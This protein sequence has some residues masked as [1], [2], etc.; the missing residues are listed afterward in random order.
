MQLT[1]SAGCRAP[2]LSLS[3]DRRHQY[4]PGRFYRTGP[5]PTGVGLTPDDGTEATKEEVP[6]C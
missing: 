2:A 5:F 3:F 6:G 4:Y 1:E